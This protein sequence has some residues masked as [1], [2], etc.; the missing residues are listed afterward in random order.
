[1]RS[2]VLWVL[3][4]SSL[5]S[6]V[7]LSRRVSKLEKT[8][9]A[10]AA[11]ADYPLGEQMGYMQRY[12]DK[13]WFAGKQGNW[14]LAKFYQGEITE[15]AEDIAHAKVVKDGIAVGSLLGSRLPP[16]VEM[17]D[18]AV[19]E[20]DPVKFEAGYRAMVESCN[21]CHAATEHAFI[22]VAVPAGPPAHWNQEF[23]KAGEGG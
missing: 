7:W 11:P 1:M 20:K 3:L 13:L 10:V 23:H 9:A 4:L 12:A 16:V 6:N 5:A 8:P 22:R 21:A 18:Q 19:E 2:S 17:V 14:E 15:T